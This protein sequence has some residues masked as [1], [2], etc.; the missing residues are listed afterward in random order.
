MFYMCST[1]GLHLIGSDGDRELRQR[2]RCDAVALSEGAV[3]L[4]LG[5]I[6]KRCEKKK[7]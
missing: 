2:E 1:C 3:E 4:D 7:S 6:F 5:N